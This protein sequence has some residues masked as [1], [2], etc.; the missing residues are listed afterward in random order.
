MV[1]HRKL[2]VYCDGASRGNPG[3]AGAGVVIQDDKGRT[4]KRLYKFLGHTTNNQAEYAALIIG[5][6]EAQKLAA[7]NVEFRLDSELVVFQLTGQYKVRNAGLQPFYQQATELL[8]GFTSY[9]ITH[10]SRTLNRGADE[11]ANK[12]I[13]GHSLL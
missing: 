9:S 7:R 1:D 10:V 2:I 8:Q 11:L 4:I 6:E 13:D 3:P 12:A 5:I